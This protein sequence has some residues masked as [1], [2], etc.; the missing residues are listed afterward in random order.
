M[1]SEK[2]FFDMSFI[3][4][5]TF[6]SLCRLAPRLWVRASLASQASFSVSVPPEGTDRLSWTRSELVDDDVGASPAIVESGAA[7]SVQHKLETRAGHGQAGTQLCDHLSTQ[8]WIPAQI[9]T[10]QGRS[11]ALR[12]HHTAYRDTMTQSTH[13]NSAVNC[14]SQARAPHAQR[15]RRSSRQGQQRRRR[16]DH[17]RLQSV[18]SYHAPQWLQTFVRQLIRAEIDLSYR[19]HLLK[20]VQTV[21]YV[22]VR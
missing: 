8:L 11:T 14:R 7:L 10:H 19:L 15:N 22:P 1:E 2:S 17:R 9:N 13:H 4:G 20:G 16:M 18:A 3:F 12:H 21:F 6:V 5:T